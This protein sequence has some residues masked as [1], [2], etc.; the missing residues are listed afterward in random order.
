MMEKSLDPNVISY[1]AGISAC[2]KGGQW[3]RALSLL[4]EMHKVKVEPNSA[5]ALE[6]VRAKVANSGSG[7]WRCFEKCGQRSWSIAQSATTLSPLRVH[8]AHGGS[9]PCRC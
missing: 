1:S 8:K 2:A 3:Q 9:W 5:T 4:R 7:L 6:S